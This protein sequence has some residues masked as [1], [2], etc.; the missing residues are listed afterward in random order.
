MKPV[1]PGERGGRYHPFND[2]DLEAIVENI[3][4]ILEE[5][6]FKDATP[7]C[8][9]T[10]EA[11]GAVLGDDGRLTHAPRCGRRRAQAS[12]TQPHASRTGPEFDLDLS[13]SRVHFATAGAAV[14]IADSIK[15]EYRDS[16]TRDLYDLARIA[17]N[18]EHIHMF[19]RMCVL[20]DLDNTYEM[21]LNT[22]YC[23][24]A[25]T[26]KHVGASWSNCDHLGKALEMLHIIA[27][28]EAA[29]RARPF[30]SQSNCFVVPPMKFAQEALEC[31]RVAVE[32]GHAR[33]ACYRR[34]K[35]AP[36]PPQRW[37][38]Q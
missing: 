32:G 20:R 19:Q 14:M 28:G 17:D 8:I 15:N 3:Y 10:C 38:A 18:C 6:G 29:W 2:Q 1:R 33:A 25:G 26:R 9:E 13:G 31:L 35:P 16:T 21:D 4:R 36:P 27:G 30:V 11:V 5:V 7:H 34:G 37:P 12:Q 23:C 22:T 24:V